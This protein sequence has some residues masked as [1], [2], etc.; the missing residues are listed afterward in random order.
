VCWKQGFEFQ[1]VPG[2]FINGLLPSQN[3]AFKVRPFLCSQMD[4][5]SDDDEWTKLSRC[6]T[7]KLFYRS[8]NSFAFLIP[9]NPFHTSLIHNK[10]I[11]KNLK[12][13]S[14]SSQEWLTRH[15]NDPYVHKAQKLNLR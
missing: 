12:G 13:K 9:G 7:A 8:R 4:Q 6:F 11:P 10:V 1:F 15:M 5:H 2:S 3:D 14:K